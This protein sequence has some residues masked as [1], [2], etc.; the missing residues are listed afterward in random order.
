MY[1]FREGQI[2]L[3]EKYGSS[4]TP[5]ER[6]YVKPPD[7]PNVVVWDE[8]KL[9]E[10]YSWL[11]HIFLPQGYPDSVSRDYI[12]YQLWDT[13]QAF[14]STITGTLATQEVLRG[15]GV[16]DTAITPLSA[17]ITWVLKDG[18]GHIGRIVFA[19]SHGSYLDAYSKKWRLYADVLNDVAMC[20]EMSLPIFKQ[21]TTFALCVSTVMKAIVGVAGGATRAAMTQHHAIRGNL[22]DVSAKDSAQ[23][24]A[25]NLIASLTAILMLYIFG[26]SVLIFIIMVILHITFNYFAVRSVCLRTLNEP[27]FLQVID[28]YLKHEVILNPCEINRHEPVIFY[29][30]GA[31]YLDLK[32]CGFKIKLGASI[33][34]VAQHNTAAAHISRIKDIYGYRKYI[35]Y[36]NVNNREIYILLKEHITTDDILCAY[37]HAVLM[38]IIICAINNVNLA[39]YRKGNDID[40]RPFAQVCYTLQASQ[41]PRIPLEKV[42]FSGFAYDAS[43]ELMS[44]VDQIVSK[45]WIRMRAGLLQTGWDVSKHLIITDEWRVHSHV[46]EHKEIRVCQHDA[47][48]DHL[49]T[50]L[51]RM[52]GVFNNV[53]GIPPTDLPGNLDSSLG[54]GDKYDKETFIIESSDCSNDSLTKKAKNKSLTGLGSRLSLSS[55]TLL[56]SKNTFTSK[57]LGSIKPPVDNSNKHPA[58]TKKN[59]LNKKDS[60]EDKLESIKSNKKADKQDL[61]L[62]SESTPSIKSSKTKKKDDSNLKD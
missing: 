59:L 36:P 14:C 26:N 34:K 23:E 24:T 62:K 11:K 29:Q 51:T 4:S 13:A 22:A 48:D 6:I 50:T 52:K 60:Q 54:L 16:G 42:G 33:K 46:I 47:N 45:E 17:T 12:T 30:L 43:Y 56:G 1:V 8:K 27:R 49:S 53:D 38:S 37:F 2:V 7:Q 3:K 61:E 35:L 9:S 32:L 15:V 58:D 21:L 10:V 28:S 57:L 31:N 20:I 5:K 55:K 41:W 44:Y 18:C 39:V 40:P 19:Y 25:V